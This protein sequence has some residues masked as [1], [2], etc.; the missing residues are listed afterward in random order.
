VV[1][2]SDLVKWEEKRRGRKGGKGKGREEKWKVEIHCP[3]KEE[4]VREWKGR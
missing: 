3:R 4:K 1:L 2:T